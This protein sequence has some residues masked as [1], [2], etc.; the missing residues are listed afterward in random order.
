M[1]LW[2][3]GHGTGPAPPWELLQRLL[4]GNPKKQQEPRELPRSSWHLD[5]NHLFVDTT[6]SLSWNPA[7][8]IC[9]NTGSLVAS[10]PRTRGHRLNGGPERTPG[11]HL[12]CHSQN[13]PQ[14]S[15]LLT[16]PRTAGEGPRRKSRR[17]REPE[18][19]LFQSSWGHIWN[20]LWGG[21]AGLCE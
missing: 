2:A 9:G 17:A 15:S 11:C 1:P 20:P 8:A 6:S 13:L 19:S 14:A 3:S 5:V 18:A 10:A 21:E 4:K 16:G 7:P 12:P